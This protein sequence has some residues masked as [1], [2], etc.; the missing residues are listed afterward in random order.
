MAEGGPRPAAAAGPGT[1]GAEPPGTEEGR[2][3]PPGTDED[4]R[5]LARAQAELLAALVAGAGAPA[6][7]DAGRLRIQTA[8]LIAKRR[9]VVAR[10]RPD[11]AAALAGDFAEEFAAYARSR[12]KPPGGY[13]AD[14]GEFAEH[15]RRTGRIAAGPAEPTGPAVPSAGRPPTADRPDRRP[16]PP[17]R[18][19]RLT[20][21]LGGGR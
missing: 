16:R 6:G 12:P 3:R 14:A 21:W 13:R 19:A 15:L 17:G 18:W 20:W 5:E 8:S 11:L 7:F 9:S 1:G 10:L 2:P 4:R